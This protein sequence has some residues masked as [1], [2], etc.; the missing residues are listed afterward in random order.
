[1]P[2]TKKVVK[3]KASAKP[4][5]KASASKKLPVPKI[6]EAKK[7]R[8]ARKAKSSFTEMLK[9]QS[10]LDVIKKAA[11][12]ELKKDYDAKIKEADDIN[13]QYKK[14]FDEDIKSAPSKGGNKKGSAKNKKLTLDQVQSFIDQFNEGGK[15]SIPGKNAI[16]IARIKEA[17]NK[18][19]A[20]DAES[21]LEVLSK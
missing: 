3:T 14:L 8:K 13:T 16:T 11:K 10:E 1:M 18:S 21:V 12:A 15:I 9:K 5:A 2:V 6:E 4:K 20:K 19:S 17:Y 7:P